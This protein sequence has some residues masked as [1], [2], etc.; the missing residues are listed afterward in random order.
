MNSCNPESATRS[1]IKD[2]MTELKV[3]KFMTTLV[4][5]FKKIES[6]FKK[7]CNSFCLGSKAETATNG[8]DIIDVFESIYSTIFSNTQ[9]Y[10]GN[11]LVLDYLFSPWS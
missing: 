6:H 7:K 5:T 1:K 3:F 4:S 8:S 11:K 9:K 2:L 10:L